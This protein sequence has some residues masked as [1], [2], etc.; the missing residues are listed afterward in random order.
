MLGL[1]ITAIGLR[2]INECLKIFQ[3]LQEPM[4]L[5]FLELAI[6]SP[7]SVDCDRLS[8]PL[9]LHDSCLYE[10]GIRQRLDLLHPKTW[11]V[12]K[13]F[14]TRHDVRAVSLHPPRRYECTQHELEVALSDLEQALGIPVYVETMPSKEYWC[15]SLKT[16]VNCSLL[17]D[18]SHILIWHRGNINLTLQTCLSIL[19]SVPVGEI[20]L[21]HNNGKADTHDLI[22]TNIWFADAIATWKQDYFV[23]FESLPVRYARF[24]RLDR[25]I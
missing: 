8:I 23:T 12:Y 2:S 24:E 14:I 17:V 1:S 16:L 20:H 13:K 21:S 7:C 22:P 15:S 4:Q 25:R 6:G 9:I 5:H 19:N 11:Q 10:N 18:V 3:I